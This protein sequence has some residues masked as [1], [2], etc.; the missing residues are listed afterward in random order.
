[1]ILRFS[2]PT[3]FWLTLV[4]ALSVGWYL[5][6]RRLTQK[7]ED[8]ANLSSGQTAVLKSVG[9]RVSYINRRLDILELDTRKVVDKLQAAGLADFALPKQV[10]HLQTHLNSLTDLTGQELAEIRKAAEK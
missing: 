5:N 4:I 9:G 3:L 1:M 10:A 8:L 6:N 7:Y 2:L